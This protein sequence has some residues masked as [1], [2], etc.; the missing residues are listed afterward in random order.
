MPMP[1]VT[2]PPGE[3]MKSLISW[4]VSWCGG[5]CGGWRVGWC[6]GRCV[7]WRVDWCVGWSVSWR[8]GWHIICKQ[9]TLV[10]SW[11]SSKSSCDTTASALKSLTCDVCDEC[12][13][14]TPV[15]HSQ[16]YSTT[17]P[18]RKTILCLSSKPK[19]SPAMSA[20]LWIQRASC[21]C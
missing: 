12:A 20:V 21:W 1:A 8:V 15:H 16:N 11:A 3:L 6:V 4:G 18:P 2:E 10:G 7:S 17:S 5:Q 14:A 13:V 9:R 19:G